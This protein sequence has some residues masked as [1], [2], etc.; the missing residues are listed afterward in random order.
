M[1]GKP[2]GLKRKPTEATPFKGIGVLYATEKYWRGQEN[3][4]KNWTEY[5]RQGIAK[6]KGVDVRDVN[7][8]TEISPK[9]DQKVYEVLADTMQTNGEV[10]IGPGGVPIYKGKELSTV[11]DLF[12]AMKDTGNYSD[13]DIIALIRSAV[14]SIRW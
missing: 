4:Y 3:G 7:L 1:E 10:T 6:E 5:A 13:S 9:V 8:W 11:D 12:Q 2:S 14:S